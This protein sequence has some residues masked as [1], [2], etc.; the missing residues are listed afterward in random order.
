[1]CPVSDERI[2]TLRREHACTHACDI[3][4]H[5]RP[6]THSTGTTFGV[7]PVPDLR[8]KNS[9]ASVS[10]SLPARSKNIGTRLLDDFDC[11]FHPA[12]MRL[13]SLLQ[14]PGTSLYHK[15]CCKINGSLFFSL[16]DASTVLQ[17]R[18]LVTIT[19]QSFV[20]VMAKIIAVLR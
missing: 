14:Y 10:D 3:H 2:T 18:D 6:F 1:M 11:V 15:N 9:R 13:L 5:Y 20:Q 12:F 19:G 4:R 17:N 8:C 7:V 16:V